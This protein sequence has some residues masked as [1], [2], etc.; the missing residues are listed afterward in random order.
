M[1]A[2][3]VPNRNRIEERPRITPGRRFPAGATPV[4]DGVNFSVWSRHA[5]AVE[6][7]LYADAS[8]AEPS[9][10]IPLDAASHRTHFWWHVHVAGLRPGAFYAWRVDGP[11]D[12]EATG[13]AF[14]PNKQ[15]CDPF[16]KAVSDRR[17]DRL[18]AAD[19]DDASAHLPRAI[20]AEPLPHA[21]NRWT[22]KGLEGA[23]IY[24]LHVG[25][26]TQ[27]ASSAVAHPGTFA[28]LVEKIPYLRDLGVTHVELLPVWAFD[29]QDVPPGTRALGLRNLWGYAPYAFH[30]PH[31]RYCLGRDG[32]RQPHE[33]RA[34]VDAFHDEG[35]G[36]LLDVVLNHTAEGRQGGPWIDYKGLFNE[37]FYHLDPADR[38][39][40]LDFTGCGN[41]INCNH[42]LVAELLVRSLEWWATRLGADGFR[43]DLASVLTRGE[44]G[45]P[46]QDPPL[47]WQIELSR[48]L[49]DR[50]LIAEAWDAAGLHHSG[51]FPGFR[52]A[53]WNGRYKDVIRKFARGDADLA[54]DVASCLTGSAGTFAASGRGPARSVNYVACHDGFTLADAVSYARKRN[55]GN[56]E[57][58]RDGRDDEPSW[59]CGIEGETTDPSVLAARARDVR[60]MTAM[61]LLSLGTPMLLAGDEMLRTQRGNNNAWCRDDETSWIDWSLAERHADV[62]RFTREM[63]ALR[64]RHPRLGED[65]W[66]TGAPVPGRGLPDIAWHGARLGRPPWEGGDP[67][68]LAW[69]VVGAGPAEPDLH[70]ILNMSDAPIEAELPAIPHRAWS[71]AVHTLR[72]S[73]D[74]IVPPGRQAPLLG[75]RIGVGPRAVVVLENRAVGA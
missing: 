8:A 1:R 2:S 55:E 47:P 75:P 69:T 31:P 37:I 71:L 10:I 54:G 18:R 38:R 11:S 13:R 48:T 34:L 22:P 30:A 60:N 20:V 3:G 33:F 29:E 52:W 73:P 50:V 46:M 14:N 74:D 61:L 36:V 5:T 66:F 17:H 4:A 7:L 19:P 40:Y 9:E 42:P 24:E 15:L 21:D 51:T 12:T 56:G 63:I 49:S 67:R 53:E 25:A 45:A 41:T 68:V 35:I 65:R 39:R 72:P 58:N 26:F 32:A 27:A 23:V 44:G 62:V 16:A 64:K 59:T 43:F 57:D 6:L 28:G 70:A